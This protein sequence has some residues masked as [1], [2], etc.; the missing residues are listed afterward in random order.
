MIDKYINAMLFNEKHRLIALGLISNN[1]PLCDI[2]I[3]LNKIYL[4]K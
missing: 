2:E 3:F 1:C 4:V